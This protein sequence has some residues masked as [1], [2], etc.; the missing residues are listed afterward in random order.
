MRFSAIS[1]VLCGL[2]LVPGVLSQASMQNTDGGPGRPTVVRTPNGGF[3]CATGGDTCLSECIMNKDG[4]EELIKNQDGSTVCSVSSSSSTSILAPTRN[5]AASSSIE[6]VFAAP[7]STGNYSSASADASRNTSLANP[8]NNKKSHTGA[9]A[10]GVVGGLAGLA[11]IGALVFFLRRRKYRRADKP[12]MLRDSAGAAAHDKS[13]TSSPT[14]HTSPV[15]GGVGGVGAAALPMGPPARQLTDPGFASNPPRPPQPPV[16]PVVLPQQQQQHQEQAL[17]TGPP[18]ELHS[19]EVDEDGVSVSSFDMQRP[20]E[21]AV[22]P[23][24][25]VYQPKG[26]G[27]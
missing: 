25:P 24:L 18:A 19:R 12:A 21:E 23:R 16:V 8:S 9:I 13:R 3:T 1:A 6:V 5:A 17:Y 7:I 4:V 11:L 2:A 20:A 22:I 14:S 26:S 15:Y 10:G 27:L